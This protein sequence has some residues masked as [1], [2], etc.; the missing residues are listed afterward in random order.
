M[1]SAYCYPLGYLLVIVIRHIG[2]RDY[3]FSNEFHCSVADLWR[4][5]LEMICNRVPNI[6]LGNAVS[7]LC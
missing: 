2:H 3:V 7:A 5:V 4:A 6:R 1:G